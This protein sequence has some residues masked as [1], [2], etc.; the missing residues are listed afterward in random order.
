MKKNDC[1]S[2]VYLQCRRPPLQNLFPFLLLFSLFLPAT[3]LSRDAAKVISGTVTNENGKLL[4]GTGV[5]VKIGAAGN[6]KGYF[7]LRIPAEAKDIVV[8]IAGYLQQER[9]I[10]DQKDFRF[11]KIVLS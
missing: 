4:A 1:F 9:K 11:T 5:T 3:A 8:S 6:E 7:G 2:S 10:D